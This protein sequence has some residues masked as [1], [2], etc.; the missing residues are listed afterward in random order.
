MDLPESPQAGIISEPST[1]SSPT[2]TPESEKMDSLLRIPRRRRR[3][4]S[5]GPTLDCSAQSSPCSPVPAFDNSS[6]TDPPK[7]PT[8]ASNNTPDGNHSPTS[9]TSHVDTKA[10]TSPTSNE[11]VGSCRRR[12]LSKERVWCVEEAGSIQVRGCMDLPE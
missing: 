6:L 11:P 1:R 3:L 12:S 2:E 8:I 9:P 10:L 5:F 7:L 4:K